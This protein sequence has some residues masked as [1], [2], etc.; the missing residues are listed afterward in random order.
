MAASGRNSPQT[1]PTSVVQLQTN[2]VQPLARSHTTNRTS[3]T[4]ERVDE[5]FEYLRDYSVLVCKEHGYAI[6]ALEDH[7]KRLH[8]TSISDRK[9]IVA[10]F[11]KDVVLPP[12]D[13]PLPPPLSAPLSCLGLPKRAFI[14]D[15]E[16]CNELSVSRDVIRIHCNKAHQWKSTPEQRTHWHRQWAQ[17]FFNAAGLQRYFTVDY[18]EPLSEAGEEDRNQPDKE[19]M[20]G[21]VTEGQSR[22]KSIMQQWDEGLHEQEKKLEVA[23]AETAKTDHTAWFKRNEWPEHLAKCNLR[24]LS[25]VSRLPDREERMLQR[26]VELNN[27]L[28]EQSVT[29]LSTLDRETRRWI[30]SAKLSE[31]DQRPLARLQNASSQQTYVTYMSRFACYSLRVLQS[32]EDR[33]RLREADEGSDDDT[34]S[35][36]DSTSRDDHSDSEASSSGDT[37]YASGMVVDVYQDAR[38]LYPWRGEQKARLVRVRQSIERGWEDA[39][40]LKAL[41]EWYES[42]IFQRVRGNAFTSALLHFLAILGINEETFRLRDANDYSYMLAGVVYCTR[43]LAIEIILPSGAREAQDEADD[44]RFRRVRDDY[45]ADGTYSVVSKMLSLLAY[46]KTIALSHSNAGTTQWEDGRKVMRYRGQPISLARLQR[47]VH[48]VI[49]EAADKLW[50]ELMWTQQNGRFDIPLD[51][52]EDDVTFTKRGISFVTNRRNG[53]MDKRGWML[54]RAFAHPEGRKLHPGESWSKLPV[55]KYLRQVDRFRELLLFLVHVTGGQPARGSEIT[56][57]RFRNGFLQDRNVFAMAG[58]MVIVTR[59]HKSQSQF[60][61]P[62]VIP[63]FLP[64]RVGQ[65]L[66]VY[67]VY[68]QPLEQF[69]GEEVRGFGYSDYVWSNEFGPWAT[70]RLT[71]IISRETRKG[72]GVRLT[73]LDYR[74]VAI[75]V[76]RE[77]VGNHF[78]RGYVE[79]ASE[80]EEAEMDDDDGLE[81]SAGR[82]SEIGANRYG[83]SLDVI[84]HLSSRSIDTF[85]PLSTEWHTFF[86]LQSFRQ[87]AGQKRA[88]HARS[89][90]SS[91]GSEQQQ[92]QRRSTLMM[93][94]NGV[95]GWAEMVARYG[96]RGGASGSS[97]LVQSDDFYSGLHSS[98]HPQTTPQTASTAVDPSFLPQTPQPHL[99]GLGLVTPGMTGGLEASPLWYRSQAVV[100][101][102]QERRAVKEEELQKAMQKALG[103]D[104]VRFRSEEQRQALH[105]VVSKDDSTPLVVVLPT[106]GGKSLLF[107][108]PACLNDP[109]ITVV[110]VPYRALLNNLLDKAKQVGIDCV[111][112][113]HAEVNPAALVFVSADKVMPFMSYA[114]VMDSKGLLR[115]VFVDESHLTFTS[116]DWRPKLEKV[117]LVRGLRVPTIMLTATLPTLLEFELEASMAAQ[118]AQY[119]RAVT[120]RIRTRYTVDICPA[121]SL[122]ERAIEVCRRTKGHLRR[123]R[124]VVYSRSRKQCE[125]LSEELGCA[126]Y[127]AGAVDHQ[128]RLDQW[129]QRG[130]LIVATS[131]L[132]TGVDFPGVVCTL[133]VD[134]PYGMIDFAQESGR[135]GRAG[136][137]VD[138]VIIVEEGRVETLA[139]LSR[140]SAG[141]DQYVMDQYITTRGCRR[142]V[143]SRYLDGQEIDCGSA[144]VVAQCDRCGGGV[145][146]LERQHTAASQE[147]QLFEDQMDEVAAACAECWVRSSTI[148][149]GVPW[150]L[151]TREECEYEPV[152]RRS[153]ETLGRVRFA[154][155]SHS[156]FRCGLSQRLC[157]TGES[158]TAACQWPGVMATFVEVVWEEDHWGELF[159][160]IGWADG[161]SGKVEEWRAWM[162]WLGQRHRRLVWGEVMSNGMAALIRFSQEQSWHKWV[163][164]GDRRAPGKVRVASPG[165][166]KDARERIRFV[167]GVLDRWAQGCMICRAYG[168]KEAYRHDSRICPQTDED[169]NSVAL[170]YREMCSRTREWQAPRCA[171][172]G[173]CWISWRRCEAVEGDE[174]QCRWSGVAT[175][176]VSALVLPQTTSQMQVERWLEQAGFATSDEQAREEK[177]RAVGE[178]MA[179]QRRWKDIESNILCEILE[180]YGEKK[181]REEEG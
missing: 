175:Q 73:T 6:R 116:S 52:L 48:D 81:I 57:I 167:G 47:M 67:L 155:E 103:S 26:V 65:L 146:E 129:L 107:M 61:K 28:V 53:L 75:G 165:V 59:Y 91:I 27:T 11:A 80:V 85:R 68:V 40:Q 72:L 62:K 128:E 142:L 30:R 41:L 119:I 176:M 82:S 161:L 106:G 168:K 2:N 159:K 118:M 134:V 114:Q 149:E 1:P 174:G 46:G 156:C 112:W 151:H 64:W 23:D 120:T 180:Q 99:Y 87:A 13:V 162:R 104:N 15:E 44:R 51:K 179:R 24:H 74:H 78:A 39:A 37:G 92:E 141:L 79:E 171:R 147:R 130:G 150:A 105:A 43:V 177:W 69:L 88:A 110:V 153:R 18:D 29:G 7:L 56:T 98:P 125:D 12:R 122:W 14:C 152:V 126:Y 124:G 36:S 42:V 178:F 102:P 135:A 97:V 113:T 17:T 158:T 50:T 60:D 121:G 148:Y 38:R 4:L 21:N 35:G 132:G 115:R 163:Q 111:E 10:H 45:L 34:D 117:R 9:A 32:C 157:R 90:S 109:G 16:D 54:E 70:D 93:Q 169:G 94:N 144:G 96:Q 31:P 76:G 137:D 131:A 181:R 101:R 145:T 55:L 86:G 66:A 5:V 71:K 127:H 84:K 133:H 49:D 170:V 139:E 173:R 100:N 164:E 25:R 136:E 3:V 63:R 140:G 143:M 154:P 108:A 58:Q 83:V 172:G 22:V 77:V 89:E 166:A 8:R 19:N 20:P 138:S 33:E 95:Y 160:E 123:R